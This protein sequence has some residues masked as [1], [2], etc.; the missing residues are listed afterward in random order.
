M[1][2][3]RELQRL[4]CLRLKEAEALF[5]AGGYDGCAYLCGYVV[6]L[7]LKAAVCATLGVVEY[8]GGRLRGALKT[9]EFDDLKLLAGMEQSFTANAARFANWSVASKWNPSGDM[10]PRGPMT[11][12]LQG[13]YWMQCGRILAEF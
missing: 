13:K 6:E 7:A 8:P 12:W 4:A 3:R 11:N 1:A 9:H 5:S 10:N 2:T